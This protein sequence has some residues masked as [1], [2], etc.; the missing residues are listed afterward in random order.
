MFGADGQTVKHRA[1]DDLESFF[2]ILWVMSVNYTGPFNQ[3]R[4]W[5]YIER[6]M[7]KLVADQSKTTVYIKE[8][9]WYE[10][11][12]E[13]D[14][15][16]PQNLGDRQSEHAIGSA[17]IWMTG[18]SSRLEAPAITPPAPP[19][20]LV[21]TLTGPTEASQ[22]L[23][24]SA[25]TPVSLPVDVSIAERLNIGL[26]AQHEHMKKVWQTQLAVHKNQRSYHVGQ[27]ASVNVPAWAKPGGHAMEYRQVA[28]DKATLSWD[29]MKAFITPYFAVEP[30]LVGMEKLHSLFKGTTSTDRGVVIWEPPS[31][32]PTHGDVIKI[33]KEMLRGLTDELDPYPGADQIR[34]GR[35][36]YESFLQDGRFPQFPPLSKA[37]LVKL[38]L[39]A[40]KKSAKSSALSDVMTSIG[41]AMVSSGSGMNKRGV[42][43]LGAVED[44]SP[45]KMTR[46]ES[47]N[48]DN[49]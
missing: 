29:M 25:S 4:D 23:P 28:M 21:P 26:K 12:E 24:T 2:W 43:S 32:P 36:R 5:E 48:H 13:P 14:E 9:K 42:D 34:D 47:L 41:G 49:S 16:T 20:F 30:F 22:P 3:T 18:R 38:P 45:T 17:S 31:K 6:L 35:E 1:C 37:P 44:G 19:T 39:P 15:P 33:L 8:G 40:R 11:A 27:F 46:I 10:P 7:T